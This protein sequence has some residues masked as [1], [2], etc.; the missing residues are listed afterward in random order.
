MALTFKTAVNKSSTFAYN[1]T[2]AVTIS[3]DA[4]RIL[5]ACIVHART[6]PNGSSAIAPTFGG[7]AMT[8]LYESTA[9]AFDEC[10]VWYMINPSSG[11]ANFYADVT[12]N[13]DKWGVVL[14]EVTGVNQI[15]PFK[16][17]YTT[18]EGTA[19]IASASAL[20][21]VAGDTVYFWTG[22]FTTDASTTDGADQ[23]RQGGAF[24]QWMSVSSTKTADGS[25]LTDW[26][27]SVGR[28]AV[29]FVIQADI[30]P[31]TVTSLLTP[32]WFF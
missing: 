32:M 22:A 23:T 21:F 7:V 4:N 13:S 9:W 17:V 27:T 25:V 24:G 11:S 5:L 29:A 15:T 2:Q 14:Q 26:A 16:T 31:S 6:A 10:S 18:G 1:V 20:D 30:P 28:V 8:N 3:S 12:G 19:S